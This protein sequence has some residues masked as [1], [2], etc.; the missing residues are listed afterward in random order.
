MVSNS[1]LGLLAG[2][3]DKNILRTFSVP[4]KITLLNTAKAEALHFSNRRDTLISNR[5]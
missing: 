2:K 1:C 5:F 4:Y 3:K